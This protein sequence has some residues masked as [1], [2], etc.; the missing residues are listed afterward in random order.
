[1]L[2]ITNRFPKG[3]IKTEIDRPFSFDLN[4]NAPSNSVYFCERQSK[5]KLVEVGSQA[6]L[7][8]L[9]EARQRQILLYIHGYS[10]LPDDVFASVEEFQALCERSGKDE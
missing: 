3:S 2:F 5:R 4:N 1:M 9:Q 8:R 10:N 7:G 6:F